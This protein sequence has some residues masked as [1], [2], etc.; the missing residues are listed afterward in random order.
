MSPLS[1]FLAKLMP[2][3]PF[4]PDQ[5][6]MDWCAVRGCP[7]TSKEGPLVG[8]THKGDLKAMCPIHFL[9]FIRLVEKRSLRA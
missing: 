5:G 3:V 4:D 6:R 7:Y 1:D 2:G 9:E 8:L